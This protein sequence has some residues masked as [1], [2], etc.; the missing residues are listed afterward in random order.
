MLDILL[1]GVQKDCIAH[2]YGRKRWWASRLGVPPLTLS[3]WLAGRQHP[4]GAHALK[5][6]EMLDWLGQ[7]DM[8][9]R[10]KGYLWDSYYGGWRVP[11][12]FLPDIIFVVLSR[13]RIDSRTLG[14]LSRIVEH[15]PVRLPMALSA[16]IQNRIGWLLEISG[17]KALFRPVRSVSTQVL[18]EAGFHSQG[19]E[20]YLKRFQTKWGKKW[21]IYD[22]PLEKI[23]KSLPWPQSWNK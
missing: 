20:R 2:G 13:N 18:L 6:R 23:K 19:L 11:Y 4:S 14:L 1:Q 8:A 16:P 12:Q 17:K 7:D 15:V 5:I 10:W 21:R 9:G 22:S 3:H